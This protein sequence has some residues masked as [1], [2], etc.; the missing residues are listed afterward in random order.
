[1]HPADPDTFPW[2]SKKAVIVV[3]GFVESEASPSFRETRYQVV[4]V[5][6]GAAC[7][8]VIGVG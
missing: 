5:S 3:P 8:V 4:P 7:C 6:D 2:A 1:L